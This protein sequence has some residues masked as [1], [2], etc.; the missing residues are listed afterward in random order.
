MSTLAWILNEPD[1]PV[2]RREAYGNDRLMKAGPEAGFDPAILQPSLV[3]LDAE[4]GVLCSPNGKALPW[5]SVI[6]PRLGSRTNSST[7]ALLALAE[8]TAPKTLILNA[9]EGIEAV[10]NKIEMHRRL[11][12][13]G[14]PVPRTLVMASLPER[15]WLVG[16][17]GFPLVVKEPVGTLGVGV[18]LAR[19][20]EDLADVMEWRAGQGHDGPLVLQRYV[21]PSHG[22][23]LRVMT[24]GGRVLGAMERR[25]SDASF[26]ANYSRG[27]TVVGVTPS[28]EIGKLALD[29]AKA[30]G[31]EFAGVDLLFGEHDRMLVAE[32]NSAPGFQGFE[33]VVKVDVAKE[34]WNYIGKRLS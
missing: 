14:L 20:Y 27:G 17:L 6:L 7:I 30:V 13:A 21:A 25:S 11:S 28:D 8:Q 16:A 31:L 19:T 10:R 26:K 34:V 4:A 33:S 5:P 3:V 23:D 24:L 15:T 18:F 2:L 32:V 22:R 1:D 29:A 12:K 9:R